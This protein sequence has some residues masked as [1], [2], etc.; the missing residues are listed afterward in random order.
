MD[1]LKDTEEIIRFLGH[2]QTLYEKLG[3]G[4]LLEV[5]IT[6]KHSGEQELEQADQLVFDLGQ[7]AYGAEQAERSLRFSLILKNLLNKDLPGV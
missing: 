3:M 5:N 2:L 4:N 7:L 1:A 6:N